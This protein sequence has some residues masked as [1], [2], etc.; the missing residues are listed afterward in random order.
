MD[1]P[2][3]P[4]VIQLKTIPIYHPNINFDGKI[5]LN[6]LRDGWQPVMTITHVIY[7]LLLLFAEPNPH[8]PLPNGIDGD[9]E[10]ANLLRKDPAKFAE[11]VT[12]TL[13]G[14][15]VK[16]LNKQFPQLIKPRG[17]VSKSNSNSGGY[18]Y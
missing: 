12:T 14:G 6:V 4:P 17:G 7:G 3:T 2:H 8:D 10:A 18:Y 5:C 9:W 13:E 1:Y 15:Y 16:R 11:M